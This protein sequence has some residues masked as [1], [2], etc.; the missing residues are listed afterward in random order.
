MRKINIIF[1]T[2]LSL[3]AGISAAAQSRDFKLGQWTE[4]HNAIVKELSRSYVD[5]LPIDKMMRK[6]VDSMLEQLDPYT[7]YIP[8]V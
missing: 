7:V 4:I 5:S 2:A 8:E 3:L 1:I 6:G